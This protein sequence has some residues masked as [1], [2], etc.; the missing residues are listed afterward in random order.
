MKGT[1]PTRLPT[2]DSN[3]TDAVPNATT[4]TSTTLRHSSNPVPGMVAMRNAS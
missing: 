3:A 1:I 4:G 2:V